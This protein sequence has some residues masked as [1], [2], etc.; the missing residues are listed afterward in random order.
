MESFFG[1]RVLSQQARKLKDSETIRWHCLGVELGASQARTRPLPPSL[2]LRPPDSRP[3]SQL[4][5]QS[6]GA[7]QEQGWA[8]DGSRSPRALY[9]KASYCGIVM[10]PII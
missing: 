5:L 10:S 4:E 6:P 1:R 2:M 9:P 8:E 3:A 7:V